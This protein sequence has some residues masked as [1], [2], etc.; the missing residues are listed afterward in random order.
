MLCFSVPRAAADTARGM[1]GPG[2]TARGIT[3]G[4]AP[5]GALD[6]FFLAFLFAHT[7]TH[8]LAHTHT[9]THTH[10]ILI[11]RGVAEV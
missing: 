5:A 1:G 3:V 8:T 6:F 9:H 7:H 2:N 11:L 4:S 10:T